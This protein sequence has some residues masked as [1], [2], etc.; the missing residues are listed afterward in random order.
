MLSIIV[1]YIYIYIYIYIWGIG[2]LGHFG[3]G[4]Y[5]YYIHVL[6]KY[7]VTNTLEYWFLSSVANLFFILQKITF[8]ENLEN[9]GFPRKKQ[10]HYWEIFKKLKEIKALL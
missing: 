8:W 1:I 4:Y 3:I 10:C 5:Q 7:C 9:H 2:V 6:G